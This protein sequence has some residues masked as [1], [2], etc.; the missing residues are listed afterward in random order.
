MTKFHITRTAIWVMHFILFKKET[1]AHEIARFRFSAACLLVNATGKNITGSY[2]NSHSNYM[3]SFVIHSKLWHSI[4]LKQN[5]KRTTFALKIYYGI[6]IHLCICVL[7]FVQNLNIG[8]FL[9]T[10]K[11]C[12]RTVNT[13]F[14]FNCISSLW[15]SHSRYQP[16]AVAPSD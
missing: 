12:Q 3:N 11:V 16:Y 5:K 14:Q 9:L 2:I 4:K 15:I 13:R 7:V 1:L 6:Y 10:S 8:L